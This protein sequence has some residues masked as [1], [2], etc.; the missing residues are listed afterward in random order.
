MKGF[1]DYHINGSNL[2]ANADLSIYSIRI[3]KVVI[4]V[5][6]GVDFTKKCRSCCGQWRGNYP[7]KKYNTYLIDGYYELLRILFYMRNAGLFFMEMK[8]RRLYLILRLS[9]PGD[10]KYYKQG[11]GK[12]PNKQFL[13]LTPYESSSKFITNPC[14]QMKQ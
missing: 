7:P 5:S 10:K 12:I 8:M 6:S 11:T 4:L 14:Q 1:K 9:R 2:Y 13:A 3:S